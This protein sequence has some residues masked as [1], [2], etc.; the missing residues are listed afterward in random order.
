MG[1]RD[2]PDNIYPSPRA[3]G[4]RARAYISAKSQLPIL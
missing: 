2:L 4:L 3:T 1:K